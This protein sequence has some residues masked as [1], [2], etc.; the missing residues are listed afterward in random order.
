MTHFY[1][2]T[3][4]CGQIGDLIAVLLPSM[5]PGH[6]YVRLVSWEDD[7][8]RTEDLPYPVFSD[9]VPTL[10][11]QRGFDVDRARWREYKD[12]GAVKW[13]EGKLAADGR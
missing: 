10:L 11:R 4:Y 3:R 7:T 2:G 8:P 13:Q 1:T 5:Q 6:H 12:V 9:Y